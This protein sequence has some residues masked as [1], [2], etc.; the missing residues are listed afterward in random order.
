MMMSRR[1][2]YLCLSLLLGASV[3]LAACGS[4]E[5][6]DGP[7]SAP[8]GK[9]IPVLMDTDKP[10]VDSS[11]SDFSIDLPSAAVNRE[12]PQNGGSVGHAPGNPVLTSS[13][14]EAWGRTIGSGSDKDFKLLASPVVGA[15]TIYTMD[16][17]GRVSAVNAEDGDRLWRVETTPSYRDGDA[18]GGGIALDSG[19]VYATTGFGEALALKASDGS[20]IWRRSLGKP[21]RSAPTV[22]E[23]RLYAISIENDT[24]ALDAQTGRVLWQQSGIAESASLMGASSAA[25]HGDTVVVAYSSGELFGL[26]AQNGRVIWGEVLAVPTKKGALPAIADIRGLPVIDRGRVFAISHSGRMVAIDERSGERV[27]E[28]DIGGFNT[29][30]MGENA[31]FV[32]TNDNQLMALTRD[33]GQ[34]IWITDLQKVADPEAHSSK[35]VIWS[36]PV[37]AG[38]RLWLTNSLGFLASYDPDDGKSRD[39]K[40]VSAPLYLSPIVSNKTMFLLSDDGHLRAFK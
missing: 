40:E 33:K 32:V 8:A 2:R 14:Q 9:R 18:M 21:I 1:S 7:P 27:W 28:A 23:G 37:L 11:V 15:K 26:R 19:I 24:F 16:A 29:P 10:K 17:I 35:P 4:D 12:W 31:L 6:T 22:A 39:S 20:V 30:C 3:L 38:G 34:I 25:V 13:P 5:S 36:G